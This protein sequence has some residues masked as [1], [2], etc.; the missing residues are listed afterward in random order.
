MRTR[1][2]ADW[3]ARQAW[4]RPNSVITTRHRLLL[5]VV[6]MLVVMF[7]LLSSSLFV[8]DACVVKTNSFGMLTATARKV[9]MA[10]AGRP[11]KRRREGPQVA[12]LHSAMF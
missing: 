7:S 11:V 6:D 4:C 12:G 10:M 9:M 8:D 2:E 3:T 1:F 5:L